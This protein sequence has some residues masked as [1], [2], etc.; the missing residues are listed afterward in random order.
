VA[1]AGFKASVLDLSCFFEGYQASVP[2]LKWTR[3]RLLQLAEACEDHARDDGAWCERY[4]RELEVPKEDALSTI[5]KAAVRLK[6]RAARDNGIKQ[7]ALIL[8]FLSDRV[9]EGPRPARHWTARD[10]QELREHAQTIRNLAN[11]RGF[12]GWVGKVRPQTSAKLFLSEAQRGTIERRIYPA[13]QQAA[14]KRYEELV[15]R[16]QEDIRRRF[17]GEPPVEQ[18]IVGALLTELETQRAFFAQLSTEPPQSAVAQ[19]APHEILLVPTLDTVIDA[20]NKTCFGT[21]FDRALAQAGCSPKALADKLLRKGIRHAE[22]V[23]RP[24]EWYKLNPVEVRNALL[25]FVR[26]YLGTDKPEAPIDLQDPCSA[27]EH[28]AQTTLVHPALENLLKGVLADWVRRS[29]PYGELNPVP[30]SHRRAHALLYCYPSDRANFDRLL[31]PILTINNSKE[32]A[33]AYQTGNP[34]VAF[35]C[36][37]QLAQPLAYLRHLPK[38]YKQGSGAPTHIDCRLYP[39]FRR[40]N[41]RPSDW[42]D[43]QALF[44]SARKLGVIRPHAGGFVLA[45]PHPELDALFAAQVPCAAWKTGKTL[46]QL[47]G[48]TEFQRAIETAFPGGTQAALADLIRQ[49]PD[50]AAQNLIRLGV[51]EGGPAGLYRYAGQPA[52]EVTK[53]LFTWTAGPL[54]G[55]SEDEFVG[56]LLAND[57][58]YSIL[59]FQVSDALVA[60]QLTVADVPRFLAGFTNA[61]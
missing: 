5:H 7:A 16:A 56:R 10:A 52:G 45:R 37:Y 14:H 21:L 9:R 36:Q 22:R 38:W 40:L 20:G 24:A 13:L 23:Y 28:A 42:D 49:E 35:L 46:H 61:L 6:E 1:E 54:S 41:Q 58:L 55:L 2:R 29:M 51:L 4:T 17:L 11:P 57:L 31:G 15:R 39:E 30:N 3:Q 60:G 18:G 32:E 34:Y 48:R 33:G 47:L 59:F 8:H 44:A 50:S 43:A 25:R 53:D 27:L 12:W 26:H 19:A